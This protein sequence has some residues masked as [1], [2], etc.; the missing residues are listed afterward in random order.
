MKTITRTGFWSDVCVLPSGRFAHVVSDRS[1]V[2]AYEGVEEQPPLWRQTLPTD[3]LRFL[4]CAPAPDGSIAAIGQA[5]DGRAWIVRAGSVEPLDVA[6]GVNPVA[7]RHDGQRWLAYTMVAPDRCREIRL[8][9]GT[10]DLQAPAGA[11]GIREV[12]ADGTVVFAESGAHGSPALTIAGY[13]FDD[14]ARD[15]GVIFG[16]VGNRIGVLLEAGPH[17][18]SLV[19]G[20]VTLGVRGA[21]NRTRLGICAMTEAGAFFAEIEQPYPPH[22][23]P[24]QTGVVPP[25]VTIT[26]YA[27]SA[28]VVPLTVVATAAITGGVVNTFTWRWR[29][30]GEPQWHSAPPVPS[31]VVHHD[32]VFDS[33]G[34]YEISLRGDGP[35]GIAETGMRRE[36]TVNPKPEPVEVLL[37]LPLPGN[38]SFQTSSGR[39]LCADLGSPDIRLVCDREQAGPWETFELMPAGNARVRL[40]AANGR[41]VTA[42]SGGGRELV[43]NRT[44]APGPWEE[45]QIALVGEDRVAIKT[46]N[47]RYV[48]ADRGAPGVVQAIGTSAGPAETFKPSRPL[49]RSFR[50]GT[51]Q[52][53]LR[54]D[55]RAFVNDAGTF[56]PIF[57]SALSIL[58]RSSDDRRTFLDWAARTGFNGIRVFAGALGWAPQSAAQ[59]R[60]ALPQLLTEAAARG[61]YV[62]VTAITDSRNG[63]YDPA[64]HFRAVARIAEQGSNAILEVANEPYHGTQAD[65]I[66]SADTLLALGRQSQLPFALGAAQDDES[67]EMGGGSYV[68]AHL[69]RGRDKWNQVRRVRELAVLGDTTRKPVL[70]NEPIGAAEVSQGGRR[71]SDPAFFFCMGALNRIFEVGGVFHSEAGLN[72][73]LPGPVQQACADAFVEGSRIVPVEDRLVF[74]NATWADSPI[75]KARF[76][77]TI[78]R[79]Y[80]GVGGS[81]AWT[82]LVGLSGDPGLELRPPWRIARRLAQRPG[83]EVLQLER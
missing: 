67:V 39:F 4:R 68:T 14:Y 52:G 12:R 3:V 56:R 83:V 33:P 28:G 51:I 80:T 6:T 44:S 73:T 1:A 41:F 65:A 18:F 50:P 15:G 49:G 69:D 61:L 32:F 72:G 13:S 38:V 77:D 82:V 5:A 2:A 20:S 66:H 62:E 74:K 63:G 59:A 40:R 57:A 79:A 53:R 60:A 46:S 8:D 27:P 16:T 25:A 35:G 70:N 47:G 23:P 22:E 34:R 78:V 7:I 19:A 9:G 55:G 31:T 58:A 26:G 76:E 42:E 48:S 54:I 64:E 17:Y 21:R 37:S 11:S 24:V 75:V 43:A 45:F 30:S 71:E 81:V 29:R 36:V 10:R